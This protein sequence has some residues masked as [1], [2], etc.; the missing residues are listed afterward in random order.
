MGLRYDLY[1]SIASGRCYLWALLMD[2]KN[3]NNFTE[4]VDS[5]EVCVLITE[6]SND[7]LNYSCPQK[8]IMR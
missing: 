5:L 1:Y 4:P 7:S 6:C 3:W 2:W 8:D